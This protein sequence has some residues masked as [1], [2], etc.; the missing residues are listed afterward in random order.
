MFECSLDKQESDVTDTL[1][2]S[3][4]PYYVGVINRHSYAH[5]RQKL[6]H[7]LRLLVGYDLLLCY[8]ADNCNIT[9]F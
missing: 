1:S 3:V 9:M 4:V 2:D 7:N 8:S 6:Y 5:I